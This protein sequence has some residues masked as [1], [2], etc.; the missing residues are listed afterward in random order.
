[1]RAVYDAGRSCFA[2]MVFLTRRTGTEVNDELIENVAP[3][4]SG[5]NT[6]VS[7]SNVITLHPGFMEGGRILT[8]R[9]E[10]D[11]TFG[12]NKL[13]I[14]VL[15][16]IVTNMNMNSNTAQIMPRFDEQYDMTFD[17]EVGVPTPSVTDQHQ[18]ARFGV[19]HQ[20]VL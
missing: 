2:L 9:P 12:S 17:Q 1:M 19:S 6:G 14:Q 4:Q 8:E 11:I 7:E 10:A 20:Q 13:L 3:T 18:D 15:I 5:P 16:M